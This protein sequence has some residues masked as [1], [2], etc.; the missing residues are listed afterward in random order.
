LHRRFPSLDAAEIHDILVDAILRLMETFDP[1]R[2]SPAGWLVFL[3][4]RAA[5]DKLRSPRTSLE[6]RE[7]LADQPA[8]NGLPTP[9]EGLIYQERLAEIRA[10]LCSLSDLERAIIEADLDAGE[11]ADAARLAARLG[12]TTGSIY[13]A[14]RRA[15]KKLLQRLDTP[16]L[17]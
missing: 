12:T 1:L 5:I 14:R 2:G 13:A 4:H 6:P 9:L 3:A 11:P 17:E 16:Q 8:A 10:A 7:P 15:R